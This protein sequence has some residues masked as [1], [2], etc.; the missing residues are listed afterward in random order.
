MQVAAV[1]RIGGASS[2]DSLVADHVDGDVVGHEVAAVHER[3]RL[4]AEG[5]PLAHVGAEDVARRDLGHG[6]VLRDELGLRPLARS[7]WPD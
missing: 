4:E 7:G 3:L 6:K 5:G 1:R 2:S